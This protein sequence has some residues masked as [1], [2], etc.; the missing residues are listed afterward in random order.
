MVALD[1]TSD[2]PRSALQRGPVFVDASGRRLR[3]VKLV[4]LGALVLAAGYVVLL[5]VALVGGPNIAAPYLPLPAA[6]AA[7]AAHD[8]PSAPSA[9]ASD[10]AGPPA[11]DG[12]PAAPAAPA[13][14]QAPSAPA[15][16]LPVAPP[17][18]S[19][20]TQHGAVSAPVAN[21]ARSTAP[22]SPGKSGTAPG[23]ATRPST[24]AHP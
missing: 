24:P 23:Q 20:A 17:I 1:E 8:L 2:Q 10:A 13:A 6:P 5:L 3:G 9:P 15:S 12:R 22:S 19:T 4:G 7:S 18:N 16:P 14:F 21:P 11:A